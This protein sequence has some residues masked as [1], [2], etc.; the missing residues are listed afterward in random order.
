MHLK[1]LFPE[2]LY[3]IL[4]PRDKQKY[5]RHAV[6]LRWSSNDLKEFLTRRLKAFL[7][8]RLA[9]KDTVE[10]LWNI[11]F[12]KK[13]HNNIYDIV[14]NPIDYILRHTLFRPR[15]IQQLCISIA[16]EYIEKKSIRTKEQFLKELPIDEDSIIDGV[17]KGTQKIVEYLITEFDTFNLK[18]IL[19]ILKYK[20]NIMD[21]GSLYNILA[22]EDLAIGNL[23][24]TEI[25]K[26]MWEIGLIG[27]FKEGEEE[28][29]QTY[30]KFKV[31]LDGYNQYHVSLFSFAW[32]N[33]TEFSH[34]DKIVI[35]PIFFDYLDSK[36]DKDKPIYNF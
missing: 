3:S 10:S 21:Y 20:N 14:E 30:R 5:D 18:R 7:P 11:L 24:T 31:F 29:K 19:Q 33:D 9:K 35:A 25:I 16:G 22:K 17:K 28:I 6:K 15:D 8:E 36:L 26:K 27:I 34:T 4:I 13:I 32:K 2:D 12:D 23:T 1:I